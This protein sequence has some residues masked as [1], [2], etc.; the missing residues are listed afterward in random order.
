ME[1]KPNK[2]AMVWYTRIYTKSNRI[3]NK[4]ELYE[5]VY[6]AHVPVIRGPGYTIKSYPF[7]V[8]YTYKSLM[9]R[10]K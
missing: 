2:T 1:M 5:Y 3:H 7:D 6:E 8:L 4:H 10:V 9:Y